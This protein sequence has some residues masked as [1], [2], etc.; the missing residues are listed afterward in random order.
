[1]AKPTP[2]SVT[3]DCRL[4]HYPNASDTTHQSCIPCEIG[5][6]KDVPGADNCTMCPVGMSTVALGMVN[7][8]DCRGK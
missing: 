8:S 1:M 4:G 7:V 6:Y 3:V 2:F 5:F